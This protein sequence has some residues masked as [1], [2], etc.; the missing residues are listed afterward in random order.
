M[1]A[2][3]FPPSLWSSIKLALLPVDKLGAR[4]G[5]KRDDLIV[6]LTSIPSRLPIL[7][8][9][10]RSLL[11]QSVSTK[12]VLWLHESLADRLPNSLRVLQSDRFCILYS[13]ETSAHRKLVNTLKTFPQHIVVTCDDD[14]IY[15]RDWLERLIAEH[16][17]HPNDIVA[18]EC[19]RIQ[20]ENNVAQAYQQWRSEVA[21]ESHRNT[22]AIG[23]GGV[24][25]P[26][27]SLDSQ[28]TDD[29]VYLAL[30]P[31]A[32]D[33]W[34]KAMSLK[35]GV[36][37]RRSSRHLPKPIPIIGSQSFSLKKHNVRQ[38]GNRIQWQNL[39]NHYK[40]E[41]PDD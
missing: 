21:G 23:Y 7:F 37:T 26:L 6:S 41:F 16:R 40:F 22:L 38:D 19:R 11:E 3:E 35:K 2:K 36:A 10:I 13:T 33:L 5:E 24:L 30:A 29:T 34:F 18:H 28:V 32:D 14:M 4:A 39:Q 12:I 27:N 1:K 31:K 20:F 15:P 17:Q 9:C 25:Y 8:L